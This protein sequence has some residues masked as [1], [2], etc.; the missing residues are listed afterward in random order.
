MTLRPED[1]M[2]RALEL[3]RQA[4]GR[5]RPNPPVG[6]LVV[7]DQAV[8]GEGFHPRAGDPHAEIFALRQ[9]GPLARGADLYVTLEPCS[10][11]GKTGP[12]TEAVIAAGVAR[13]FVGT[14]DPNPL[15]AG[16]G[17][18]ALRAAGIEVVAGLAE[19]DCRWLIGPFAKHI[20]TGLPLLTLKAALTLDGRTATASGDSQWISGPL[21]REHVHQVRNRVDAVMVGIGTVLQDDPRLTTRLP[22]G[23]GRDPLRIV[24]DS[25]LR[26]PET[27]RLLAC[28]DPAGVL[29]VATESAAVSRV[30]HFRERGHQVLI[31]SGSGPQVDLRDLLQRLGGM[32]IQNIIL[33][34]G[35]RLNGAALADGLIDRVMLYLAPILMGGD[36]GYGL[37]AGPGPQRLAEALALDGLRVT[38][39]GKDMLI[40][41]EVQRCLPG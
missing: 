9:A 3:A 21:S 23:A 1:Y 31:L 8:V 30:D 14:R 18:A 12:C 11:T 41:G 24:V 10:H 5:T 39:I 25:R 36:D 19:Q 7:R 16:R 35:R 34:G 40:E 20:T 6:A 27:A 13:V 29:L 17:I 22:A 37:F 4:E 38:R 2:Q 33:E 32:G 15:V 26:I 28:G